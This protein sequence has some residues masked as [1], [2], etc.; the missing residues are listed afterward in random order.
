MNSAFEYACPHV[1]PRQI[2]AFAKAK[3]DKL[4]LQKPED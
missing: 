4:R 2:Q 1:T 3:Q